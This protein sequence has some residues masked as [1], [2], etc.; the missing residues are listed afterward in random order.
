M[1][2]TTTA[3]PGTGDLGSSALLRRIA[4]TL[5][6]LVLVR[7]GS[8]IPLPALS[9][10]ILDRLAAL[11]ASDPL[12]RMGADRVSILCLGLMPALNAALVAELLLLSAWM[13]AKVEASPRARS[14]VRAAVVAGSLCFAAIQGYGIATAIAMMDGALA[15]PGAGFVAVVTATAVAATAL[16]LWLADTVTRF[17][18][19]RGFWVLFTA[20]LAASFLSDAAR[21][22]QGQDLLL[23]AGQADALLVAAFAI[24][25]IALVVLL[26]RASPSPA[27]RDQLL[28]PPILAVTAAGWTALPAALAMEPG[29]IGQLEALS[30]MAPRPLA[31]LLIL[32]PLVTVLRARAIWLADETAGSRGGASGLG[33]ATPTSTRFLDTPAFRHAL[34]VS[35]AM[36]AILVGGRFLQASIA[37]PLSFDGSTLILLT[38]VATDVMRRR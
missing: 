8:Q 12:G 34:I 23:E 18:L 37:M 35:A 6:A 5:G 26:V 22:Y 16:L 3:R 15:G 7:L 30:P 17:G 36:L 4:V 28:W 11:A 25:A 19:G 29:S 9:E 10:S 14:N 21:L 20:P 2:E 32:V 1:S 31:A 27:S 33:L 13:R 24:A 38:L